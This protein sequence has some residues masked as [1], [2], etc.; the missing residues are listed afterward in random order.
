MGQLRILELCEKAKIALGPKF[1]IKAFHNL[2][3][4]FGSMPLDVLAQ[5]EDSGIADGGR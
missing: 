2:V 1:S 4:R 3:L 5:E